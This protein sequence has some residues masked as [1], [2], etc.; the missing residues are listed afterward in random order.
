M[1]TLG[2]AQ[3][4]QFAQGESI[5]VCASA[6]GWGKRVSFF[7]GMTLSGS[8]IN[9]VDLF[10]GSHKLLCFFQLSRI[11][12]PSRKFVRL[13]L[14]ATSNHVQVTLKI[15][16]GGT[17]FS[18]VCMQTL[19]NFGP[20][21]DQVKGELNMMGDHNKNVIWTLLLSL[22]ALVTTFQQKY[23]NYQLVVTLNE[24]VGLYCRYTHWTTCR[25]LCLVCPWY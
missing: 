15:L 14:A 7:R 9:S 25:H 10:H 17:T 20:F 5:R 3:S 16:E 24:I 13:L 12:C 4:G 21:G 18:W 2:L 1:K 11:P 19:R 8:V 23:H 22:L 6:V